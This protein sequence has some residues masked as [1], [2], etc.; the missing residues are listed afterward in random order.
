MNKTSKNSKLKVN[1]IVSNV[2]ETKSLIIDDI[3]KAI[4]QFKMMINQNQDYFQKNR[5]TF[6]STW[7]KPGSLTP[8]LGIL[9]SK[10][11]LTKQTLDK[12]NKNAKVMGKMLNHIVRE[13]KSSSDALD[14]DF[15]V[16]FK[17]FDLVVQ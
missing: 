4:Q 13:N 6:K 12:D 14:E 1:I 10:Q 11:E 9:V 3:R 16:M 2:T 8:L 7:S 15:F 17:S 5:E